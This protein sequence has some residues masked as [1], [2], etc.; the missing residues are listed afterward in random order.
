M[1]SNVPSDLMPGYETSIGRCVN[2]VRQ[3]SGWVAKGCE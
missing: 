2:V 1:A 3:G